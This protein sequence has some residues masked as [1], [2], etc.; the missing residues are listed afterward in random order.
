MIEFKLTNK[1][2]VEVLESQKKYISSL[3]KINENINNE[4]V[5]AFDI[6]KDKVIIG[7][8]M[9]K[10]FEEHCFFL[11]NYAVDYKYQ[12][13]HLGTKALK[14]L[15]SYM[16]ANYNMKLMTTTYTIG[17]NQAKHLYE[18][19][20]FIETSVVDEENCHEVNMT[21]KIK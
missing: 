5:I 19:I 8:A 12:N 2:N 18:K 9:L 17:N 10:E 16:I 1:M 15:I 14:E 3:K 13:K 21:Y 7:F 6:Y 11:W 20:G 4:D